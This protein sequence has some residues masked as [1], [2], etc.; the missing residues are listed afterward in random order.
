MKGGRLR[1]D[2]LP[3]LELENVLLADGAEIVAAHGKAR[4]IHRTRDIDVAGDEV[5]GSVRRVLGRKLPTSYYVGHGHVVDSRLTS[6]PQMDVVIAD[7]SGSPVLFMAENG[8]EYFPYEPVY[9]IGEVKST[10]Y[11][12]ARHIDK[13]A[14]NVARL[15]AELQREPHGRTWARVSMSGKTSRRV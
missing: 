3:R 7:N 6:R 2:A 12:R 4:L 14:D 13:F 1:P 10:Y 9:A 15:R 5:E 8:T 11:R